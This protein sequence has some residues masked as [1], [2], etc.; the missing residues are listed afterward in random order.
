MRAIYVFFGMV[1]SGKSTLAR[2]FADRHLLP[3][4]NTDRV[5]KELADLELTSKRPDGLNQ[6][7]YTAEFTSR[8]Y[9]A[10]LDYAEKDIRSGNK[11]VVLDG[12]Y[13]RREERSRIRQLA[14]NVDAVSIFIQCVCSDDV[15]K[16]RLEMRALDPKAVSDGRWE[17]YQAQ[18]K[19][20]AIPDE[21]P[22]SELIILDTEDTVSRLLDKLEEKLAGLKGKNAAG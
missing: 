12:S 6:G 18:K 4:Y 1:A 16:K 20:F 7:I 11:G 15:V 22:A 9:G 17:I 13:H 21:I 2:E 8:T 10:M 5:R 19:S 14:I 3:Y